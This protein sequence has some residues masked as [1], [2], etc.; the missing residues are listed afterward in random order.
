MATTQLMSVVNNSSVLIN[1]NYLEHDK[2]DAQIDVRHA[3][4]F[5]YPPIPWCSSE[6]EFEKIGLLIEFANSSKKFALWQQKGNDGD[7]VR[8]SRDGTWSAPSESNHLP[9]YHQ[10]G[11]QISIV[12][13]DSEAKGFMLDWFRKNL[14]AESAPEGT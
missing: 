10:V 14:A 7:F 1:V 8:W 11:G 4:E 13:D 3:R 9:G 5:F 2:H 12:V 6:G